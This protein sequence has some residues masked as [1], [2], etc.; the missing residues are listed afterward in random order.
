MGNGT[1]NLEKIYRAL[2]IKNPEPSVSERVQLVAQVHDFEDLAPPHRAPTGAWGGD[3]ILAA[4]QRTSFQIIPKAPGG[5]MLWYFDFG[6]S[7]LQFRTTP[8]VEAALILRVP[9]AIFSTEVPVCQVLSGTLAVSPV[10]AN[11]SPSWGTANRFQAMNVKPLWIPPGQTLLFSH[12]TPGVT[13]PNWTVIVSDVT[14][15][16]NPEA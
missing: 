3:Q 14:A 15:T 1:F 13:V 4:G 8:T 2:G 9:R 5:A 16:E 12:D 10:V 11:A 7:I 6:T